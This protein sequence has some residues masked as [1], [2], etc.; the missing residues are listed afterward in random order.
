MYMSH[1]KTVG[2]VMT[3][4]GA[5]NL[6]KYFFVLCLRIPEFNALWKDIVHK[7]QSLCPQFT[8]IYAFV[9]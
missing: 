1:N 3:R 6:N 8:G 7:P 2:C 5:K 9:F 4:Q